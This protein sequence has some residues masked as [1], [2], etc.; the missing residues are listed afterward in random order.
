MQDVQIGNFD[1]PSF[2]YVVASY[3]PSA[4]RIQNQEGN[5]MRRKKNFSV[6]ALLS[7]IG[8]VVILVLFTAGVCAALRRRIFV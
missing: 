5:E 8:T 1:W 7:G 3:S 6:N 2:A 4:I